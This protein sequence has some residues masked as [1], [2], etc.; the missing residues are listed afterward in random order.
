MSLDRITQRN[1][2]LAESLQDGSRKNALLE[3]MDKT[4]TPMGARLIRQ[5]VKQPLLSIEEISKRQDTVQA[6]INQPQYIDQLES[7][8]EGV[9][10][11]ERLMM[12]IKSGYASP[13]D[14]AALRYS[15]EP[16]PKIK[17]VLQPLVPASGLL[18][19]EERKIESLPEMTAHIANAIVDD[20]PMRLTEGKI[21]RDGYNR[22]LDDLRE[23][24][25]DSKSWIARYQ[26]EIREK[27]GIRTL[28][29]GFTKMFGYYIEVSRGQ[30]EKMP[31][32]FQRRQT[33]VN[34]ERYITPELK[35]YET[36]VLT[37]EERIAAI[38]A[39]LFNVLRIEIA[40]YAPVVLK[41]A[42]ALA[43]IDCLL[44]LA[45]IA[46]T[47]DYARP[48]VDNSMTLQI[49]AGRHP[50]I[51]GSNIGEKFIPNDT[52]LDDKANRLLLITGPNMAGKSTYIQAGSP[53]S[54]HGTNRLVH[55]CKKRSY[56]HYRQSLHANWSER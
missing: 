21:F 12:R 39:E 52:F 55:T 41:I 33:L 46:R 47:Y 32:S 9:R 24:A 25:R 4:R 23:I 56:R 54:H 51:E 49:I 50:V 7:L 48:I 45:Q 5:W 35:D 13:R 30:S 34:A 6:F 15:F 29:V 2:E 16:I 31:D 43:N 36:K 37:A 27:T 14:L 10:D 44:S 17:A 40:K 1:L 38:E 19:S 53:Y 26:N 18:E 22:E 3:L 8:L 20:P 28:K 42:Q 11:L